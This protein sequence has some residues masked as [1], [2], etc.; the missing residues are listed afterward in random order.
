MLHFKHNYNYVT[1]ATMYQ[2][3]NRHLNLGL[4]DPVIEQDFE[5]LAESEA[6][7]WNDEHPAPQ[8]VGIPHERAVCRWLDEQSTK[9]LEA[10]APKDAD[11]MRVFRESLG[12]A[13]RVIFD[14]GIPAEVD[15]Q[16]VGEV[17]LDDMII[18]KGLVRDP[19]RGAELPLLTIRANHADT[20][21]IVVWSSET[22]KSAAFDDQGRP[23]VLLTNLLGAGATVMLPDLLHQGEF[24]KHGDESDQQPLVEDERSY[25]AFTFGYNRTLVSH[26]CADLLAIIAHALKQEPTSVRLLGT[27]GSAPWVAPAAVLSGQAVVRV[28][29]DTEG[30]RFAAVRSYG[31]ANFAP[32][33]VKYGDLPVLLA[34][35]AP[36]R[37]SIVG[38]AEL[39]GI[40][41][42]SYAATGAPDAIRLSTSKAIDDSNVDWL[43]Q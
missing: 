5:P 41:E 18:S 2:W 1:R 6:E 25:S 30:F 35:R 10:L 15:Y 40:V 23:T 4:D 34:L 14:Q 16:A 31:D 43:M 33:A 13:W 27:H 11:S 42:K 22:G 39:P 8:E 26:R 17:A 21:T 36:H 19:A 29:I 9:Q 32:G 20:K 24:H 28:A 12:G 3:M 7:V 37:L 38:E